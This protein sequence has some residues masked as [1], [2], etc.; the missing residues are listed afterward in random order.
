M[1][2]R[3]RKGFIGWLKSLLPAKAAPLSDIEQARRLIAAINRGGIPLNPSRVNAVARNLG[4]EIAKKAPVEETIER[5]R[6]AV[7][8]AS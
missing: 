8:R 1:A 5:L 2:P 6:K 7:A 4:L 3:R